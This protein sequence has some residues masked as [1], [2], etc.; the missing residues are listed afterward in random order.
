[1]SSQA[2]V[3]IRLGLF[4]CIHLYRGVRMPLKLIVTVAKKIPGL[5]DYSS[6]QSSCSIEGELHSGEDPLAAAARLHGQAQLAVDRFLGL[7]GPQASTRAV[8]DRRSPSQASAP[9]QRQRPKSTPATEA[10]IAYL[11][12][13]MRDTD[14]ELT[15]VLSNHQVPD[16]QSLASHQASALIAHLNIAKKAAA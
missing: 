15:E 12:R 9:M 8:T 4:V 14:T 10:Q 16:L 5:Q 11:C 6:I 3:V 13:L 7:P 2:Q 1:M